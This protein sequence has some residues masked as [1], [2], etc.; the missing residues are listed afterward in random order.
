MP[1]STYTGKAGHLAAMS[2]LALRGYNVATPEIDK[3]DDVFAVNDRTGAMWR[4]QVKT[5]NVRAGA[6]TERFS[7]RARESAIQNPQSPELYFIFVMR[8]ANRTWMFAVI[9]R[10]V[11]RNYA[12][13]GLGT[14]H[15]G[16]RTINMSLHLQAQTLHGA[17]H[18]L[19]HHINDWGT[20]PP[21]P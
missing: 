18:N 10:P 13:N 12:H 17:G 15:N 20:W 11:L 3:G 9:E 5:S 19:T 4:L 7:F 21:L 6:R 16:Y 2:E 14:L 8:R 1:D